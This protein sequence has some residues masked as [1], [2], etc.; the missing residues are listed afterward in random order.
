MCVCNLLQLRESSSVIAPSGGVLQVLAKCVS[1]G[2]ECR[3]EVLQGQL[4]TARAQ[5]EEE[6][7]SERDT[8]VSIVLI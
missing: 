5:E 3:V 7:Q 4:G 8:Q 1:Q 6:E 2:R